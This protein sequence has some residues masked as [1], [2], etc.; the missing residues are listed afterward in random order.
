[1][2]RFLA[3]AF[4]VLVLALVGVSL[5]ALSPVEAAPLLSHPAAPPQQGVGEEPLSPGRRPR[6]RRPG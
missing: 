3:W 2:R 1:M 5:I 6:S 4:V